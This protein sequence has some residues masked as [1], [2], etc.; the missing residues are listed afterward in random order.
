[1]EPAKTIKEKIRHSLHLKMA[2]GL[3]WQSAPGWTAASV[4]LILIQ[5][6]LPLVSLYLMKLIVDAVA[7]GLAAPGKPEALERI[8]L[9]IV[10]AAAAA[11]FSA[12]CRSLTE[13]VR[14]AQTQVITDH[15]AD[16]IHGKSVAVDLEYYEDP[17]Y[18]DTLHRAQQEATYRPASIMYNLVQIGQSGISLAA[19]AGLLIFFRWWVAVILFAAT[20][21]GVWLRLR[22]ANL[23]YT[24]QRRHT[25]AQR[26]A[27][28]FHRLVTDGGHAKEIRLF[29]L[30]SL[31]MA[32]FRE[33]RKT[34]RVERLK[35]STRRSLADLTSQASATLAIF[36]TLAYVAY[37]TVQGAITL[38]DMVMYYGAFQRAQSSLQDVWSSLT[39][40]YEDN[41]F[42]ANFNEFLNLQPILVEPAV[43]AAFPRPIQQGILVNGVNFHYPPGERAVLEDINL[44]IL[45]GQVVALVGENGSGKTTLIKLLCRLYDPVRGNIT[46]DGIDLRQFDPRALRKESSV[47]LQDYAHYSLT[48]RENIWLGDIGLSS[49]DDKIYAAARQTQADDFIQKLP[50]GYETVLGH[51]FEDQGELSLGEWQKLALARAFLREAQLIILDEP[52]SWMDARAE[53]EVFKSFRQLFQGRMVLLISHRFSTVRLADFIYVLEGG[54]IIESGT[55]D[56]LIQ[57]GGKYAQLFEIQAASYR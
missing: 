20:I 24:W 33:L 39:S 46:I 28:Y 26:R 50:R 13:I 55:H 54:R 31:F 34:L 35:I 3:V 23:M 15:V 12:C 44:R 14:E 52:T 37:Q 5:G 2:L 8:I 1:M 9:L 38:G 48:A 27:D 7:A 56:E 53:Y 19:M 29:G 10:I 42:L 17:K 30:G 36:G 49:R 21:P 41:L 32:W 18:Y 11:L 4:G 40:L 6:L 45:P 22:Y 16:V 47:I 57:I 43:P 25:K 51:E